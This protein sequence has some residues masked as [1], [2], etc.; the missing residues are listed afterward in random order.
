MT[1]SPLCSAAASGSCTF[2]VT[3][4]KAFPDTSWMGSCTA[5]ASTG[6]GAIVTVAAAGKTTTTAT[7]TFRDFSAAANAVTSAVCEGWE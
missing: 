4:P 3:F 7:V 2:T 1:G 5:E 6:A